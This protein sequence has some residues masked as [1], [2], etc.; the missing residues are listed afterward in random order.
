M[1]FIRFDMSEYMERHTV[2]RLIGA[3]PGYVGFDQGGLLTDSIHKTP[4]A[5]LLLD[6]IEKAHPDLF[7][8]L[9]Q[10]LE[11]GVL[12][13][14][15]GNHIDFKNV[16]LIMTSNI[17]ARFIQKRGHLGFQSSARQQQTNVE[18]GVMQA[19][20]QTFNPEFINRLDEIIVF[21]PLTDNDL[22]EIV[23]LLVAQLNRTLIRRKLQVQMTP[24]AKR[25]IVEKTCT[26][27]SYGARPL[28]RAL[29]KH[30]EDPL[31]E[32]LISGRFSEASVIEVFLEDNALQYRPMALEE[33]GD[34]LLVQ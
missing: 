19:V 26:D 23:G 10:V 7:N 1:A 11:D 6:E 12:T 5:V 33:M 17:G 8:I 4:H 14:S 24:E 3:P 15:L 32:A 2:S 30:V 20:K 16:I 29:Q 21:E 34:A 31:S 22:F 27:R 28:R 25:W 9:L 18:E 13:D